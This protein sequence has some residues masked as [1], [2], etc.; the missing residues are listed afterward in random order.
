MDAP[1]IAKDYWRLSPNSKLL[2]V[3]YA[4]RADESTHRCV[5][6]AS[7]RACCRSRVHHTRFVN[8]T[9][10]NLN[11]KKDINPFAIREPKMHIKGVK[12]GYV[13]SCMSTM[14]LIES[15]GSRGRRANAMRTSRINLC[16]AP[17]LKL[18]SC[19]RSCSNI[20]Y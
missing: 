5:C 14:P 12:P 2:D 13:N 7:A 18:R 10:A 3:M 16:K 17:S 20:L 19:E 1:A 4:V 15:E 11:I 6:T 9:F 8:H